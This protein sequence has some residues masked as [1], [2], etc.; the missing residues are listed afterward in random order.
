MIKKDATITNERLLYLINNYPKE[1]KSKEPK[2]KLE[3]A[4]LLYDNFWK[5]L[6]FK[7]KR[8][9][10][11]RYNYTSPE[12]K[13][14]RND[15]DI[16]YK[17]LCN[18]LKSENCNTSKANYIMA[19]CKYFRC[20]SDY[21]L[22]F[23]D[24]PTHAKTDFYEMTGLWDNCI[25]TLSEC[26]KNKSFDNSFAEYNQNIIMLLNYLLYHGKDKI[27]NYNK[28]TLLNDIFNYLVFSDF[29]SYTDNKGIPQG[30]H[31]SFIDKNGRSLCSLPASNMYNAIKLN[32]NSTLDI[33]KKDIKD[34]GCIMLE[35][36]SLE[37]LFNEIKE[38]QDKIKKYDV[39]LDQILES[40]NPKERKN[41]IGILERCKGL[42]FEQ[43]HVAESNIV[44]NYKDILKKKNFSAY[45]DWQQLILQK[46][47]VENEYYL[48][49]KL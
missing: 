34:S 2:S 41:S 10:N 26:K 43:I 6:G 20:S 19:Y 39:E 17:E 21:L 5:L 29:D 1:R 45:L 33:L 14:F 27:M 15:I 46:L 49:D 30:S 12:N 48:T 38:N 24:F 37:E 3:F 11:K 44:F 13:S 18:D 42:C 4:R 22:G 9:I 36:P 35:K 40:A 7:E 23:I 47:Y 28:I 32:I 31:I 16:V 25:D 8:N